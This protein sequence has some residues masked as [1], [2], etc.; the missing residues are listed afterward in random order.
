MWQQAVVTCALLFFKTKTHLVRSI[1]KGTFFL[2]GGGNDEVLSNRADG[3]NRINGSNRID[4]ES[5][6]D[7]RYEKFLN[8][9]NGKS[10]DIDE[11]HNDISNNCRLYGSYLYHREEIIYGAT[12][13]YANI[14]NRISNSNPF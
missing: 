6:S 11:C 2:G 10:I 9:S 5:F 12:N 1:V 14:S 13:S 4:G 8:Y 3:P 7:I